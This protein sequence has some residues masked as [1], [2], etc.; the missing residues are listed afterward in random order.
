MASG[1]QDN[2]DEIT[3]I[4]VTPLVDVMLVLLIIFMVTATYI[5]NQAINVNLPKADTGENSAKSKNLA[6][7]LDSKSQLYLNGDPISFDDL[8]SR[9]EAEKGKDG[10]SELHALI[11]ADK[12]TPHGSVVKLIDTVRKHGIT[13]FAINVE[14]GASKQ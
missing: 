8:G 4:N 10:P 1:T 13:D 14:A 2:D 5:V 12:E 6:F 7:V 11:A 3:G 9:I